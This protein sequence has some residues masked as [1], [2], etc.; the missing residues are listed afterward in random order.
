MLRAAGGRGLAALRSERERER[1]L[2]AGRR[3][4]TNGFRLSSPSGLRATRMSPAWSATHSWPTTLF[5]G[6]VVCWA[7]AQGQ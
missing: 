6:F 2:F 4:G 7:F 1:R 3:D 5:R